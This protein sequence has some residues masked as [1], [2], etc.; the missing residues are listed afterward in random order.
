MQAIGNGRERGLISR[1][2]KVVYIM[3]RQNV[4][5]KSHFY[6]KAPKTVKQS[7]GE[8]VSEPLIQL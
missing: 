7:T 1:E 6:K 2:R 8:Q 4:A 3:T 5:L